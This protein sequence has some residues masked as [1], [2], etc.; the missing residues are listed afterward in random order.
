MPE[1]KTYD[2]F[3]SHAWTYNS[4]Y[5]R[6]LEMIQN[7]P[8]MK[9]RDYSVPEHDP[10]LVKT[11]KGL[12]EALIR[13]IRPVNAVLVIAGMYV[14]YRRWIQR[15]IEIAQALNKPIIGVIPWGQE[16]VPTEVQ[17]VAKTMV[18]WNTSTIVDAIRKYSI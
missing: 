10:L 1:L 13:Q 3:I 11:D 16:R 12:D 14:N 4:E 9:T 5:Y 15:E 8:F 18:G 2:V 17:N 6:L 7:A